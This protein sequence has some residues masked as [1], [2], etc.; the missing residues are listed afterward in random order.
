VKSAHLIDPKTGYPFQNE[1]ISVTVVAPDALTA[2]AYDNALMGM[3]LAQALA[4]LQRHASLQAYL[5]YQRSDGTVA[6]TATQGFQR[7]LS[8]E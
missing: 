2:D 7:L 8:P 5:I 6:D 3:G 1:L 4:F